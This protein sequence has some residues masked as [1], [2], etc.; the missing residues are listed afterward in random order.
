MIRNIVK[1]FVCVVVLA[2][3]ATASEYLV[4]DA[5]ITDIGNSNMRL[6]VFEK[7]NGDTFVK[8][9]KIAYEKTVKY[10]NKTVCYGGKSTVDCSDIKK[11][12]FIRCVEKNGYIVKI[13][14]DKMI[15]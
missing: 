8:N 11:K 2:T 4:F 3:S 6:V 13:V 9:K 14:V 12:T 7:Q 5:Q 10:D 15:Q 1:L